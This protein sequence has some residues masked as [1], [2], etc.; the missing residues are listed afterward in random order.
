VQELE[1]LSS[2]GLHLLGLEIKNE[3]AGLG[4]ISDV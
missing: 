2:K 1:R 4:E 3:Y